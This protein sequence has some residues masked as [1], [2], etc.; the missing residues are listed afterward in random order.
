MTEKMI[1][2][3]ADFI[4]VWKLASDYDG[5]KIFT[6]ATI[7]DIKAHNKRVNELRGRNVE[8]VGN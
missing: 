7:R 5:I 1:L 3:V 6:E 8:S 2:E 4:E